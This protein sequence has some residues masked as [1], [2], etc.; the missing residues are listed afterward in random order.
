MSGLAA[1]TF[2]LRPCRQPRTSAHPCQDR[3]GHSA[4]SDRGAAPPAMS[5]VLAPWA[6]RGMRSALGAAPPR[7]SRGVRRRAHTSYAL[8][9]RNA[10]LV[11]LAREGE[12]NG[13]R[14]RLVLRPP[15]D[16]QVRP[17]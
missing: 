15:P 13:P 16:S 17:D 14:V 10:R 12:R 7:S 5:L 6:G 1:N 3:Q 9:R 11:D 4:A 2:A 8:A